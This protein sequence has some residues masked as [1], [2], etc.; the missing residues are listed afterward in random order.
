MFCW[1]PWNTHK[2]TA[3]EPNGEIM[4]GRVV[5]FIPCFNNFNLLNMYLKHFP[6]LYVSQRPLWMGTLPDILQPF[7]LICA[8]TLGNAPATCCC[9]ASQLRFCSSKA[10]ELPRRNY[11]GQE[12][13]E[14]SV[15]DF[16]FAATTPPKNGE[17][18]ESFWS[19]EYGDVSLIFL[20]GWCLPTKMDWNGLR[21]VIVWD[22]PHILWARNPLEP[23]ISCPYP[24]CQ[25]NRRVWINWK[26]PSTSCFF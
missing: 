2:D 4:F 1:C 21:V 3:S 18:L 13:W 24:G 22:T 7:P 15:V 5:S 12:S 10:L 25:S 14:E 16:Y 19:W 11:W 6:N 8:S 23:N 17:T 9:L 20:G 26:A